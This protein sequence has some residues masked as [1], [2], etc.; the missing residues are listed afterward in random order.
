MLYLEIITPEKRLFTGEIKIIKLPGN[1]GSFEIMEKHAPIISTL[2]SGEIRVK[3][4][5]G[6]TLIFEINEGLVEASNNI[7]KVLVES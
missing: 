5:N 7:V 6:Q 2:G 1:L 4:I 3:D